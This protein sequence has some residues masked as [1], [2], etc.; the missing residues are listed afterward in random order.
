G[1][2]LGCLAV[3]ER[4]GELIKE[5]EEE[6]AAAAEEAGAE[7]GGTRRPLTLRE[8]ED[9]VVRSCLVPVGG[10]PSAE[11]VSPVEFLFSGRR[12]VSVSG[13]VRAAAIEQALFEGDEEGRTLATLVLDCLKRCPTD[14]RRAVAQ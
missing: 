6:E 11:Q 4:V 7:A 1:V 12:R 5:E 2:P 13:S 10:V 3:Q 8:L 14:C 9:V